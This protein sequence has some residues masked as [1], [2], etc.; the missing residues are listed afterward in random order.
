MPF[1][2]GLA[3]RDAGFSTSISGALNVGSNPGRRIVG[4]FGHA[5]GDATA[6]ITAADITYAGSNAGVTLAP[7]PPHLL[8][9]GSNQK[10]RWFHIDVPSGTTGSNT[11]AVADADN[12][13]STLVLIAMAY[14]GIS[15]V[16]A[17][18]Y[19]ADA[20]NTTPTITLTSAAGEEVV[21]LLC[22]YDNDGAAFTPGTGSSFLAGFSTGN[23]LAF[24]EDGAAS[25]TIDGSWAGAHARV[26][27][28]FS[29]QQST[30]SVDQEGARFGNDDGSES[31]HTFAAAQDANHTAPVGTAA[32][33]RALLNG[34]G[35][36]ASAAFTLRYQKNGSGGYV[37]VPVGASVPEAYGTVTFGA[38]GTGANGGAT[39]APSYPAGITAGQYLTC[40]VSSGAT[41]SET[42][43]T[44]AGWTLLATG[45]STDGTYEVDAGPRR[46]TVFGKVADGTES[47]TLTVNITNGGTC[48]GTIARWTKAGAGAWVVT[49]QGGNDST[50]GTGFSATLASMN[51]NTGDAVLVAVGQRVDTATQSAQ[52][53]T[54]SG[55][56]FGTRTNRETTAVTTGNDHRHV[57]DTFAAVTGTSNVNAGPTWA[58]TG[59][60]ACS[61][62]VVV[63]R[64]REYTAPVTNELF[65]EA[66]ANIPGGGE[67]TTA[68]LTPPASKTTG[69]FVAGRR[70]DDAAAWTGDITTD[71]YTELEWRINTQAPAV[72]GD[73]FDVRVYAGAAALTAYS[74]TPR[75]TLGA[76]Q[77]PAPR[78]LLRWDALALP[79][80]FSWGRKGL[81]AGRF[82]PPV[83]PSSASSARG[84][85]RA[86]VV[87]RKGA[88]ADVAGRLAATA[89]ASGGKAAPATSS[90]RAGGGGLAAGAKAAAATSS[91]RAGGG[92]LAAGAKAA[93]ATSSARVGARASS[94]SSAS[95][96][97]VTA[98]AARAGAA[99]AAA[100]AKGAAASV[101]GRLAATAA[102]ATLRGAAGAQDGRLGL[103]GSVG[104]Q[105]AAAGS[106]EASAGGS[107]AAVGAK[108]A[109]VATAGRL[110][111]RGSVSAAAVAGVTAIVAGRAGARAG[112]VTTKGGPASSAAGGGVRAASSAAKASGAVAQARAGARAEAVGFRLTR[113]TAVGSRGGV[114]GGVVGGKAA[115]ASTEARLGARA[116]AAQVAG[117]VPSWPGG[118]PGRLGADSLAAGGGRLGSR[119][120]AAV[121][122]RLGSWVIRR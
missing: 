70:L 113:T 110:G 35:D 96:V 42:P 43:T 77:Q 33:I 81:R 7:D 83:V 87:T 106:L 37:P 40:H 120:L 34:T 20:F 31:A 58:Y 30:A 95:A 84:G 122:A 121:L 8:A 27:C 88:A 50:S 98:A 44:P 62:G 102:V 41:N 76:A 118:G 15:G 16:S 52:S 28:A 117:V 73:Y 75:L 9:F 112:A 19:A 21:G 97:V 103:R 38:I 1:V 26:Y 93:T 68:R 72:V 80:P 71:D 66:S 2:A 56:T 32:L 61:G 86:E 100:S 57:V 92:G 74:V 82:P 69:D 105:K 115:G 108:G 24:R 101:G 5:G 14:D 79:V 99:A 51:W 91:A 114:R 94:S 54:A 85:A 48:R 53:L 111:A 11:L 13:G 116:D 29:L 18:A 36:P 12:T 23:L 78:R 39:V 65:I 107:G 104:A 3:V 49:A 17:A 47:G 89:A 64:L 4:L 25:V 60:A 45:A 10:W 109:A 55:V 46:M 67:A 6:D 63:V 59:S 22:N 119:T 90:A